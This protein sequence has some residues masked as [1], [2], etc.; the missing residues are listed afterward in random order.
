M[1]ENIR[2]TETLRRPMLRLTANSVVDDRLVAI[3][4]LMDGLWILIRFVDIASRFVNNDI[5]SR[6]TGYRAYI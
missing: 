2:N 5:D 1:S 3:Q 4:P 6:L